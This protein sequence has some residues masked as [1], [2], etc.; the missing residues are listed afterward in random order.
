MNKTSLFF[1]LIFSVFF[2]YHTAHAFTDDLYENDPA[3]YATNYSDTYIVNASSYSPPYG[4]AT[5]HNTGVPAS[6]EVYINSSIVSILNSDTS[7]GAYI[8]IKF[9]SNGCEF[10]KYKADVVVGW[11]V[12]NM[13]TTTCTTPINFA[14]GYTQMQE[15]NHGGSYPTYWQPFVGGNSSSGNPQVAIKVSSYT[16]GSPPVSAITSITP[17]NSATTASTSVNVGA[18]YYLADPDAGNYS[19][20][21]NVL[22]VYLHRTDGIGTPDQ[23]YNFTPVANTSTTISHN[24]TLPTNT[25]WDMRWDLSGS[26]YYLISPF[27]NSTNF[28]VVSDPSVGTSG[29]TTCSITDLAGCFQNALV[30]LFYPSSASLSQYNGLYMQ[31]IN[32]PPFGYI[33][34]IQTALKNINDTATSAF[35][36]QSMPIL[37]TYI[38]DPL[39][40]AIAWILW[41]AFAF[42]LYHRLKNI[43]I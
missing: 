3:S 15:E 28:S 29:Y 5:V 4:T 23:S 18:T 1:I 34:G 21:P 43:A 7:A 26:G 42:V 40:T 20:F 37:N 14:T 25:T 2:S 41:V 35:T 19:S 11:N 38:F 31:F 22:K 33:V 24:F 13:Q 27:G 36:L 9:S 16:T 8:G 39:R 32:K 30:Y 6:V 10:D 17:A 12:L